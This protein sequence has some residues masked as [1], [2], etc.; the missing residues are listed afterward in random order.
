MTTKTLHERSVH[1]DAPVDKV[2]D[3]MKDPRHFLE[4]FPEKDRKDMAITEVNLTPEGVGSTTTMIGRMFVFHVKWVLTR[5]EYVPNT[6]IVDHANLGGVWTSTF[7]P[8][9]TGTTLS[10]A[11]GWSS[12]VPLV[13]EL[14]DRVGWSGDTDLDTMLANVKKSVEG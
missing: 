7:T 6:R 4:M 9:E 1:I 13:G 3:Y 8:D 12:R 14:A 10:L 11:F 5:E 2:F